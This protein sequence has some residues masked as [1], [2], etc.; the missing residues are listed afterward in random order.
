MALQKYAMAMGLRNVP[1]AIGFHFVLP[2]PP[3]WSKAKRAQYNGQLHQSGSGPDL[4][5]LIKAVLDCL[6]YGR[7]INDAHVA[8]FLFAQ[9][10]WGDTGSVGIYI[11]EDDTNQ[12]EKLK[13]CLKIASGN[14]R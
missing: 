14:N 7:S 6:T 4:D 13:E 10:T 12:L 9:K 1:S 3:S 11:P 8:V 2:M 5:N